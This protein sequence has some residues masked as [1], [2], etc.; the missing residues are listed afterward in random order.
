MERFQGAMFTDYLEKAQALTSLAGDKGLSLTQL[1]LA[2]VL[3]LPTI[4][5]VLVGAKTPDQVEE[6][7]GAVGVRF[8]DDELEH[9]DKILSDAA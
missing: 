3:R 2:W 1:A 7:L 8:S 9:I 6:H 4:T 5:C